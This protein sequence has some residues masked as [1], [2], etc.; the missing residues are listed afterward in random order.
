MCVTYN[1][2]LKKYLAMYVGTDAP[3][4]VFRTADE[5]WGEWS[6]AETVA[7][8]SDYEGLY[9]GFTHESL[10]TDDGRVLCML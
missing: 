6:D 7:L 4:L 3:D 9:G 2:Y 8:Q 1:R 10:C 5:P